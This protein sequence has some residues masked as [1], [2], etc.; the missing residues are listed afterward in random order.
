MG[1]AAGKDIYRRLGVKI[2]SLTF[3]APW[4]ET[5]HALLKE[6][7][8]PEE[9]ELVARM[10]FTLTPFDR[11]KSITGYNEADLRKLL[12][13]LCSKGLVMDLWLSDSYHYMPSPLIVGIF[14]LTMMRTAPDQ[15]WKKTSRLFHDY[16]ITQRDFLAANCSHTER[17][18]LLRT[19]PHEDVIDKEDY[20]EILDYERASAII[21]EWLQTRT[22]AQKER[23][24]RSPIRLSA[25]AA[26][27][28]RYSARAGH[29]PLSARR[30]GS[31]RL[32]LHLS[33]LC[34]SALK[35]VLSRISFLITPGA[36]RTNLCG[37][38]SEDFFVSPL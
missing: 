11:L 6:L 24:S 38:L 9:A 15:D 29:W 14:E 23:K 20:V 16:M 3:R 18:A 33:A 22:V 25:W 32:R 37:A 10:P 31:L 8:A 12:D 1:H 26:E 34:C 2:D 19:L 36:R 35:G 21:G 4:N 13:N 7:Y 17:V 27:C 28:V 5:F 30:S